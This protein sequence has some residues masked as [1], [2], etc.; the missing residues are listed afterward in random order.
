MGEACRLVPAQAGA[1]GTNGVEASIP[2]TNGGI[3]ISLRVISSLIRC[4]FPPDGG[5]MTGQIYGFNAFSSGFGF[6]PISA[7]CTWNW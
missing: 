3:F 7:N 2:S 6:E 1:R 4:N 5:R